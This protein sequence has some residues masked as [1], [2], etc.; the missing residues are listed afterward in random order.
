MEVYFL[1]KCLLEKQRGSVFW[2]THPMVAI[3]KAGGESKA[4]VRARLRVIARLGSEQGWGQSKAGGESKA[5]ASS[6]TLGS[7]SGPLLL[8]CRCMSSKLRRCAKSVWG[9]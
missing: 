4:G 3:T 5:G 6:S 8:P 1:K 9:A 2:L 7:H